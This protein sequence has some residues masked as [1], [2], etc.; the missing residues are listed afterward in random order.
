MGIH[1]LLI[2]LKKI[3]ISKNISDFKGQ[4]LGID[5]SC[6]IHQSFFCFKKLKLTG[7]V[8]EDLKTIHSSNIF[9]YFIKA[10]IKLVTKYCEVIVVFDGINLF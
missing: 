9:L 3:R 1:K 8:S 5:I 6:W 2:T 7:K 4:T 10:R